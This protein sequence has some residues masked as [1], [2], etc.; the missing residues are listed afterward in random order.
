MWRKAV[1]GLLV[2]VLFFAAVELV[3]ALTGVRPR[4]YA[5]D[6]YVGFSG[7]SRLF[8]PR[9]L[10]NGEEVYQTADA[11][12]RF[13]NPQQFPVDKARGT[14]RIF[15]VGGSTTFGRPY[16]DATSFCGW[17]RALLPVAD[18]SRSWEL[19]NAG[20]VSYASYRV[21]LLME[22]LADYDPDVF[23]IYTGHNEFL[24]RRTYRDI[25]AIPRAVRG[26]GALANHLRLATV[27]RAAAKRLEGKA[28]APDATVL[29]QEVTTLLDESIGPEAYDR[30]DDLR[31]K[32]LQHF[33]FNLARMI[34]IARAAGAKPVLVVPASNLRSCTPFKS[35]LRDDLNASERAQITALVR[36]GVASVQAGDSAAALK[37]TDDA[38]AIDDRVA[39]LWFMRGR[40]LE[41]LGRY[42]EARV[43]FGRAKEEDICP[44]RA[45]A[46]VPQIVREVAAD[47]GVTVVDFEALA[48]THAP[49]G[50]PGD[51]LFLDHVHPTIEGNRLLA[52]QLLDALADDEIVSPG[53][54]WGEAA[55]AAVT[56]R[57]ESSLDPLDHALALMKLSKVLGWAGKIREA[58]QLAQRSVERYP[59]DSR[60]QYQAG[61]T[62]DR[63]NRLDEAIAHYSQAVAIQADADLPHGD[64]GV[65]L[66]RKGR[67]SEAL[68][69]LRLAVRHA[70]A[71]ATAQRFGGFL[72]EALKAEGTRLYSQNLG[73]E[74]AELF[75]EAADRAPGDD[76][77][78]ARLA[79]SQL[80]AGRAADAAASY[81]RLVARRPDD[82]AAHN[83]FALALALGGDTAAAAN[84][85]RRAVELDPS[86]PS[87]AQDAARVLA[88][89]GRAAA[90]AAL[91]AALRPSQ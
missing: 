39:E 41:Q 36:Q 13:F 46:E 66:L 69:H 78:L 56:E 25:I 67:T 17:L 22:E 15:C 12:L 18:P 75:Q 23:I 33:R 59:G 19:V 1:Y 24:E 90:A 60:I 45:L 10:N 82:A 64:L 80:A 91:H 28:P 11:K 47:R 88:R 44:L 43:A 81:R 73:S 4:S 63:L 77:L 52:L 3:L 74:A 86:I 49:H 9:R 65:A 72:L 35:V 34:D 26:V 30:D 16:G 89:Q 61:L 53:P 76:D 6:P 85:Y 5:E 68:E 40:A 57:V 21:A 50:I 7:V 83:R 70:R 79:L 87:S 31:D 84:A 32:V 27:I 62:A 48:V 20:G 54:D 58:Y 42:D 14:V 8:E 71:P 38:L 2:T 29:N 55:I 37:A 51:D